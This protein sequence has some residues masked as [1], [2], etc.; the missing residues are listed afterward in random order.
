MGRA[1]DLL[2]RF[3]GD[4]TTKAARRPRDEGRSAGVTVHRIELGKIQPDPDQPRRVFDDEYLAE[5]AE[6][7]KLHGQLQPIRVRWDAAATTYRIIAGECRWRAARKAGIPA[8]EAIV[9]DDAISL[10]AV[11]VEQVVENLQ[12]HDLSKTDTARAYKTLIDSW[13]ITARELAGRLG[14][15]EATVSRALAVLKLPEGDRAAIDAGKASVA[16]AVVR[17]PRPKKSRR[18]ER[19]RFRL[20]SGPTVEIRAKAGADLLAAARELVAELE[21]RRKAA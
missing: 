12:R 7:L 1:E 9:V 6:S 14:V 16:K 21:A 2:Q 11:R 8:L 18:L 3:A 19:H 13:G 5:L 10:E 15:S 17:A 4:F 20:P